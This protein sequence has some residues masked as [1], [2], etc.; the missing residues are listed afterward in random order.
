MS[1]RHVN[2]IGARPSYSRQSSTYSRRPQLPQIPWLARRFWVWMAAGAT[3]ALLIL[4]IIA[5]A[6]TIS[7][8]TVQGQKTLTKDQVTTL[9]KEGLKR[10][11]LGR[12]LLLV[13]TAGLGSYMKE[14]EPAIKTVTIERAFPRT[15]KASI[16]ERQPSLNW[17]T[18]GDIFL[19][20]ADGTVI[21]PT[22]GEYA[23][24]PI[25]TDTNNLPVKAG[26]RVVPTSFVSFCLEIVGLLPSLGYQVSGL[27]I[28]ASTSEVYVQTS[29]KLTLKFD[30]TR[31]AGE[32]IADLKQVQAEL[33]KSRKNPTQYIDLRIPHKAYYK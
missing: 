28:P 13:N 8:I 16:I 4:V 10:Q 2:R 30:T 6:T 17:K 20:D 14:N 23:K 33:R 12:N 22:A 29:N 15:L 24:L 11:W 1:R 31:S 25:V 3:A 18:A 32:E 7:N 26:D 27:S 21:S 9:A 5:R 19:L